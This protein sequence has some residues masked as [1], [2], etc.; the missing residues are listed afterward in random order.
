MCEFVNVSNNKS[1]GIKWKIQNMNCHFVTQARA[2]MRC[3]VIFFFVVLILNV[4]SAEY[5]Y[6]RPQN[7]K[8]MTKSLV[9]MKF[10]V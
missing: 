10:S 5:S 9:L 2:D 1:H 8:G 7:G 3:L 4:I 6:A